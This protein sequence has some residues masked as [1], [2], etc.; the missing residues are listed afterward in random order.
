[1][2]SHLLVIFFTILIF[3]IQAQQQIEWRQTNGLDSTIVYALIGNNK[4]FYAGTNIGISIS[5]DNGNNWE[6]L[7]NNS[8]SANTKALAINKNGDLFAGTWNGILRSTDN[9]FSW[10]SINEGLTDK[11]ITSLAI[12]ADENIYAGSQYFLF[13]SVDNGGHWNK[14]NLGE[15]LFITS[16]LITSKGIIL[17]GGHAGLF[18]STDN[19]K[20]WNNN[21]PGLTNEY[22]YSLAETPSGDILAG[23]RFYGGVFRSTDDGKNWSNLNEDLKKFYQISSIYS[24]SVGDLFIITELGTFR[25]INNGIT[26]IRFDIKLENTVY[27]QCLVSTEEGNLLVGTYNSGVIKSKQTV[28]TTLSNDYKFQNFPNPFNNTTT[29]QYEIPANTKVSIKIY[30]I[31]GKE[32]RTVYEGE[33]TPGRYF[34]IIDGT[35]LASGVYLVRLVTNDYTKTIKTVLLK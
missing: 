22:I 29:I 30:D 35:N 15:S 4:Y 31:L 17:V 21:N 25:S 13:E 23:T 5:T 8:S 28:T 32:V 27:A 26:W 7:I 14:I 9:G 6:T 3:P 20:L 16:V 10:N 2:K 18:K 24:N 33:K 12:N 1:L 19:G 11:F 34:T